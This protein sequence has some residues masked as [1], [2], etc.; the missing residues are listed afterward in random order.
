MTSPVVTLPLSLQL[1]PQPGTYY[2]YTMTALGRRLIAGV[3]SAP[4]RRRHRTLMAGLGSVGTGVEIAAG[5]L[6]TTPG[7]AR[8]GDDVYVGPRGYIAAD[9]GLTIERGAMIGPLVYIQTSTHV[10]EGSDLLALPY[11][12]RIRRGPVIIGEFAWL[13]GRV[14]V[15]PNVTIG[16]GSVVGAGSVVVADVPPMTIVAGNPARPLRARD[17]AA[18]ERLRQQGMSHRRLVGGGLSDIWLN[19]V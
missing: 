2:A 15:L 4:A 10:F 13:G 8:I 3:I 1:R 7:A 5:T 12:H 18:F 17:G 14:T 9:G 6:I 16:T 19:D 11:D